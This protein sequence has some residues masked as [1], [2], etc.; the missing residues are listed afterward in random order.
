VWRVRS[1]VST[2]TT[3]YIDFIPSACPYTHH[4]V[5][6]TRPTPPPQ[7]GR[8]PPTDAPLCRLL[9]MITAVY[10]ELDSQT[11]TLANLCANTW[12]LKSANCEAVCAADGARSEAGGGSIAARF[13]RF[14]IRAHCLRVIFFTVP[15]LC[16]HVGVLVHVLGIHKKIIFT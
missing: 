15:S 7:Q 4:G 11:H 12:R 5:R 3:E 13:K 2:S 8:Q 10:I 6:T 1:S 16:P 9:H 14:V